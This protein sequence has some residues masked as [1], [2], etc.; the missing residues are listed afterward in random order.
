MWDARFHKE[1]VNGQE[2]ALQVRQGLAWSSQGSL[3]QEPQ[4]AP[5]ALVDR[6]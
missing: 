3:P 4:D 1:N 5:Q 2:E 6:S